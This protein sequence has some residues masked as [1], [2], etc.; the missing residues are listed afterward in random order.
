MR[1]ALDSSV[2]V[3]YF[4]DSDKEHANGVK[5]VDEI[6]A[7]GIDYACVSKINIAET[8]YVIE[9]KTNDET[10]AYNC[11][12]ALINDLGL[13]VLEF[14][15]EFMITLAHFKAMNPVSFCDNA[16]LAAA[17]MTNSRAI[18]TREKELVERERG[19]VQ[20]SRVTFLDEFPF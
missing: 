14:T 11:M 13:D 2:L 17:K 15:W 8:G 7:G 16:T 9:R 3:G 10:F 12:H 6:L 20:G 19:K 18:F 1:V 5:L 4:M